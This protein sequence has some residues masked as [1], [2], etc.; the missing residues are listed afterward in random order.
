MG[1]P[2][3]KAGKAERPSPPTDYMDPG[4]RDQFAAELAKRLNS[5]VSKEQRSQVVAQV[6]SLVSEERFS[7]PI[8]HPKHMREYEDICPGSADR[9]VR[10]AEQQLDH[11]QRMQEIAL[12]GDIQDMRDGRRFGFAALLALIIGAVVC[13][14]MG[15][16][17]LALAFL[18]ASALGVVGALIRGRGGRA[19]KDEA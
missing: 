1:K 10:M 18:G 17:T 15:S 13:G 2:P 5:L 19:G 8:A 16:Q 7:G 11:A 6:V 14:I 4:E 12:R 3:E 9:I